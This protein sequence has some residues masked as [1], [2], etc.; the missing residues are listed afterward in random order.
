MRERGK[1]IIITIIIIILLLIISIIIIIF[2][3][4]KPILRF[5]YFL[6]AR[7]RVVMHVRNRDFDGIPFPFF[8]V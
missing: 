8:E 4:D 5:V 6:L 1:I 7:S 2:L 3:S